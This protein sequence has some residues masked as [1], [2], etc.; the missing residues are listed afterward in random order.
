MS[1]T[2]ERPALVL[3]GWSKLPFLPTSI[4]AVGWLC[5][6]YLCCLHAITLTLTS[7]F[8]SINIPFLNSLPY[9]LSCIPVSYL[10][11]KSSEQPP[12]CSTG[13]VFSKYLRPH[14]INVLFQVLARVQFSKW[15]HLKTSQFCLFFA[16]ARPLWK[17]LDLKQTIYFM[18]PYRLSQTVYTHSVFLGHPINFCF[19]NGYNYNWWPIYLDF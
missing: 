9:M 19:S 5:A 14:K 6:F 11:G 15:F 16:C 13:S 2:R 3:L 18:W 1:C 4:F 8:C 12:S 7:H 17:K 10:H